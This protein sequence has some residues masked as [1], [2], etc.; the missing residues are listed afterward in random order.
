MKKLVFIVFACALMSCGAETATYSSASLAAGTGK[1]KK[2][3]CQGWRG[4]SG[5]PERCV[6]I[7]APTKALCGHLE[8]DHE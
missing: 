6:N 4:D 5:D 8:S 2:C 7:K 3:G 1:C